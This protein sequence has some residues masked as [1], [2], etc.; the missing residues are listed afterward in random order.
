MAWGGGGHAQ[1]SGTYGREEGKINCARFRVSA[2][3]PTRL[4]TSSTGD[5]ALRCQLALALGAHNM[6]A[7]LNE[8]IL[9]VTR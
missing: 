4:C 9:P 3:S 6:T 7:V 2:L 5:L 1:A 8:E